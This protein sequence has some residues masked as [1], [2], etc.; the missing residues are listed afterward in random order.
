M[1][2]EFFFRLIVL[3]KV[4]SELGYKAPRSEWSKNIEMLNENEV[5]EWWVLRLMEV[6]R[7]RPRGAIVEV[8]DGW[9]IRNY[10]ARKDR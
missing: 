4:G 6:Q 8:P 1:L 2:R 3:S 9:S 5:S 10:I 7:H